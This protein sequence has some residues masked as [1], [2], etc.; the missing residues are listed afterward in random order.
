[1][2][3]LSIIM[4]CSLSLSLFADGWKSPT[5]SPTGVS[6]YRKK[7]EEKAKSRWTLQDWLAQK[8]RNKMM[9][10]WLGMYSPS[11]YELILGGNYS[12]YTLKADNPVSSTQKNT[13]SGRLAF[14][15]LALGIEGFYQNN[16]GENFVES[17]GAVA[18]RLAGKAVQNTHLILQLGARTKTGANYNFQNQFAAL[19][20]DIYVQSHSGLHGQYRYYQ[21]TTDATLGQVSGR[22]W[23]A[24]IF[25]DIGVMK[26]F[27]NWLSDIQTQ[28]NAGSTVNYDRSGMNSGILF[29]F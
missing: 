18:F 6:D 27:G 22:R 25:F 2:K 9:D 3:M 8:E 14:Y 11:P 12:D 10:L 23:E 28:T 26:L 20:L 21:P 16:L 17:G 1:M 24:G 19:D 13:Y 5:S 7:A 4:I 29:F 15:A